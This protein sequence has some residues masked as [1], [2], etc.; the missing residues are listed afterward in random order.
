MSFDKYIEIA[1]LVAPPVGIQYIPLK[2]DFSGE[3]CL[4]YSAFMICLLQST[5]YAPQVDVSLPLI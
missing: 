5:S 1:P 4:N 2:T 3:F